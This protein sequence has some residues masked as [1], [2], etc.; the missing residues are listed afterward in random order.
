M[1]ALQAL[2]EAFGLAAKGLKSA[3]PTAPVNSTS[4]A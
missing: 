1:L 2:R 3:D 4:L